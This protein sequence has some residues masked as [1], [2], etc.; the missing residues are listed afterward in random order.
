METTTEKWRREMIMNFDLLIM[1]WW[2]GF[3]SR[4][5]LKYSRSRVRFAAGPLNYLFFPSSSLVVS[6]EVVAVQLLYLHHP[7]ISEAYG[8]LYCSFVTLLLMLSYTLVSV[9]ASHSTATYIQHLKMLEI[10][11]YDVFLSNLEGSLL[12]SMY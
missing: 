2:A 5:L 6:M 10:T 1:D 12:V 9:C 4:G 7:V 8:S 11:Y 3:G